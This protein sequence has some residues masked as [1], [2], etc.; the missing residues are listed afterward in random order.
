QLISQ[1]NDKKFMDALLRQCLNGKL[2]MKKLF[3]ELSRLLQNSPNAYLTTIKTLASCLND[4]SSRNPLYSNFVSLLITIVIMQNLHHSDITGFGELLS[5]CIELLWRSQDRSLSILTTKRVFHAIMDVEGV[6]GVLISEAPSHHCLERILFNFNMIDRIEREKLFKAV[7]VI[8]ALIDKCPEHDDVAIKLSECKACSSLIETLR[9]YQSTERTL[10][11]T[12]NTLP[13]MLHEMDMLNSN[14]QCATSTITNRSIFLSIQD[15]QYFTLLNMEIPQRVSD[16]F[17]VLQ[18][19]ELRKINSFRDLIKSLPC[20]KCHKNALAYFCPSKYLSLLEEEYE[21]FADI[22]G[23]SKAPECL[24]R[25]PF[26]FDDNDNLGPWDVLL[27]EDTIEDIRQLKSTR[28]IE[29]VTKK[30]GQISSGEWEK[31]EFKPINQCHSVP[32]YMI[33]IPG[34]ENLKILWQVDYGFS[35]RKYSFTQLI[36]VWA[37]TTVPEKMEE[38]LENLE[39]THKLYTAEHS[40]MC[41]T[42]QIG[43][44]G[45][46]L[47]ITFEGEEVIKSSG[48]KLCDSQ[49]DD[50]K[51]IEIHKMLITNKFTPIS[52]KFFQAL[53]KGGSDFTFQVSKLEYEFINHPTSA[54]VIGRSGTAKTTCIVFRLIASYLAN[55]NYEALSLHEN[56]ESSRGYYKRQIFI[57]VSNN[58]CRRIKRYFKRLKESVMFAEKK[59]SKAQFRNIDMTDKKKNDELISQQKVDKDNENEEF[60]FSSTISDEPLNFVDYETFITKYWPHLSDHYRQTLDGELVYSEFSVIKGTNIEVNYLSREDYRAISTKKYPM[61]CYDRDNIY[62]LF[63]RYENM[64]SRNGDYD[65]VDRT[66]AIL[67]YAK[68]HA[69]GGPLIHEVYIDECQDNQIVDIALI[70]KLFDRADGI[71]LAGDIAQCIERGS[72]FRFQNVRSLLYLWELKRPLTNYNRRGIIK[73]KQFEMKINYRSHNEIL[74]LASSVID[75]IWHFFP[76]SI[77][78]PSCEHSEVGGPKPAI[79]NELSAEE[80]FLKVFSSVEV[81]GKHATNHIEFGAKQIIIVRDDDDKEVVM[82]LVGEAAMVETVFDCKG[83]EFD[84]VLL[85]NFFK[86]SPARKKWRVI[87]SVLD[88]NEKGTPTFSHEKHCTLSSKFKQLYVAVTRA[89]QRICIFDEN[90]EYSDPIRSYWEQKGLIE[91]IRDKDEIIT[92]VKKIAKKGNVEDWKQQGEEFLEKENYEKAMFCFKKS[93]NEELYDIANAYNLRKIARASTIKSS[94]NA[95]KKKNF[96]RAAEAFKKCSNSFMEASCYKEGGMYEKAG[97]IYVELKKYEHAAFCYCNAKIWPKAGEYFEKINKYNEAVL[98]Y[99]NGKL[100]EIVIDLMERKKSEINNTTFDNT[101]RSLYSHYYQEKNEEMCKKVLSFLKTQ[102]ERYK[103]LRPY[104]KD[105][106]S[107]GR[108]EEASDML[109]HNVKNYNSFTESLQYLLHLCRIN[110]L[111]AIYTVE[112]VDL[113]RL[114]LLQKESNITEEAQLLYRINALN[115]IMDTVELDRILEKAHN[116]T[117]KAKLQLDTSNKPQHW[118]N[119]VKE[120][121]LYIAYLNNDLEQ[122]YKCVIFF[123]NRE[124]FITEFRAISIWLKLSQISQTN[125]HDK[126][127]R[128]LELLLRLHKLVVPFMSQHNNVE[129][130]EKI[131]KDFEKIFVVSTVKNK[132]KKNKRQISFD[133]YLIINKMNAKKEYWQVYEKDVIYRAISKS[134]SSY[135]REL[136]LK[137]DEIGRNIPDIASEICNELSFSGKCQKSD[138]DCR[139]HHVKPTPLILYDRLKLASLQYIVIRQLDM[140]NKEFNYLQRFWAEN[141]IRNHFRF[142]SPQISCPEATDLAIFE[143]HTSVY[144]GFIDLIYKKWLDEEINPND[145]ASL[146]KYLFVS[147]QLRRDKLIFRKLHDKISEKKFNHEEIMEKFVSFILS[148]YP[149]YPKQTTRAISFDNIFQ[150]IDYVINNAESVKLDSFDAFN[151]LTSLIE[152]TTSLIFAIGPKDSDFCF[153][154]SYFF[155]YYYP[156]KIDLLSNQCDEKKHLESIL[157]KI[158]QFFNL[159]ISKHQV[160]PTIILRL[161]QHL[162]LIGLNESKYEQEILKFFKR[163]SEESDY[164]QFRKCPHY[165]QFKK[166]LEG[167]NIGDIIKILNEDLRRTGCD[168]LVIAHYRYIKSRRVFPYLGPKVKKIIYEESHLFYSRLRW[169]SKFF[170]KHK[171]AGKIQNWFRQIQKRKEFRLIYDSTF[172]KIFNNVMNFCKIS[173][174][175]KGKTAIYKYYLRDKLESCLESLEELKFIH[176]EDVQLAIDLLS[177]ENEKHKEKDVAWLKN[178]LE[179]A[180]NIISKVLEWIGECKDIM[181][182]EE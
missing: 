139:R 108:F 28:V 87:H 143:M 3:N 149:I 16:L 77:D 152:L 131:R 97:D 154:Q 50:E 134:L 173:I 128:W 138:S 136:I 18:A 164:D 91:I 144:E 56:N 23:A 124:D 74:K 122:V 121:Q 157:D 159:L 127:W 167:S 153:P 43:Q 105:L 47:P 174:K 57:T 27:S 4:I 148:L 6:L 11:I 66:L 129:K 2:E 146:L 15:E 76:D 166:Y 155:N 158:Q 51:L 24:F 102:D 21:E 172:Y 34:N 12:N 55:Q 84:V 78:K 161:I 112:L 44:D 20:P 46:I 140:I 64:K 48:D 75:L 130:A 29:T 99:V 142:Q 120:L 169:S 58:L 135:I 5:S 103:L 90:D 170:Q 25:L 182:S 73:P 79:F 137:T 119:L 100:Y 106:C 116:I 69:L 83:M 60:R 117:E 54:I 178:E 94:D 168:F 33:E 171:A 125:I 70:L 113:K 9:D 17:K 85:Y 89:R 80:F 39:M 41:T 180:N 10:L 30:L 176:Y 115:A 37:I 13:P 22:G 177:I 126:Y 36:K 35:I 19:L 26:E 88:K 31:Y 162:V 110:A 92:Y 32:I 1:N 118:E 68:K 59:L 98:A 7:D 151:D 160:Y 38:M 147:V 65:S 96:T 123:K 42:R 8:M 150:F 95:T 114:L 14:H 86:N 53:A 179:K 71:F 111:N 104:V 156:F 63:L 145:F 109:I 67:R 101:I 163:L 165:V 133:N 93:R 181:K 175:E 49:L 141:L 62:D 61:F 45:V 132:N 40:H 82:K 107:N 81:Q 72:S 52:T